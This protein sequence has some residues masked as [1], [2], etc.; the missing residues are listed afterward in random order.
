MPNPISLVYAASGPRDYGAKPV[1]PYRRDAWEFQLIVSG[2]CTATFGQGHRLP[3]E[4]GYLWL[5]QP[6]CVHG[7]GGAAAGVRC[8]VAVLHFTAVPDVLR[9]WL[10]D[11][12]WLR[13]A[14]P[15]PALDDV[16]ALACA[17][18]QSWSD[19]DTLRHLRAVASVHRLALHVMAS[20][21]GA[22]AGQA[23]RSERAV[24]QAVSWCDAHLADSPGVAAMARVAGV[25]V[26]HLRRLCGEVRGM[27][28][29]QALAATRMRRAQLLLEQPELKLEAIAQA[30]GFSCGAAFSRAFKA[31]TGLSPSRW[32]A[33][34]AVR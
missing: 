24:E 16:V 4:A 28:P 23:G 9:L 17:A 1:L 26:S 34:H 11:R 19:P 8:S 2:R 12:P 5:F 31:A 21:P 33:E 14:L 13:V 27:S 15:P 10:A 22:L 25:S 18:A 20:A 30:V 29:R 6:G 32:R 7:W 3:A